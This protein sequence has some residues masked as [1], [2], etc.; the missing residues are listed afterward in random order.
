MLD[1]DKKSGLV[2]LN[3]SGLQNQT[4]Y[5]QMNNYSRQVTVD[6]SSVENDANANTMT[7]SDL[8][9]TT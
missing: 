8:M 6:V 2:T 3:G 7:P 5:Q 4:Y 1:G 9:F